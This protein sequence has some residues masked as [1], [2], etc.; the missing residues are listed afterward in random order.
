[1]GYTVYENICFHKMALKKR[2]SFILIFYFKVGTK[3]Q[4]PVHTLSSVT[5]ELVA[6]LLRKMASTDIAV[7]SRVHDFHHNYSFH[8]CIYF[9]EYVTNVKSQN[10]S[11]FVLENKKHANYYLTS[12]SLMFSLANSSRFFTV[13]S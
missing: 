2:V 12:A 5:V 9:L 1:M 7:A 10:Q 11:L 6:R 3:M 4:F 13:L 8:I